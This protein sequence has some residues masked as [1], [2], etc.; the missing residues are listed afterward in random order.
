[1]WRFL[2]KDFISKLLVVDPKRR[3]DAKAALKHPF[4]TKRCPNLTTVPPSASTAATVSTPKSS[5]PI[6]PLH[7]FYADLDADPSIFDARSIESLNSVSDDEDKPSVKSFE[8]TDTVIGPATHAS[9]ERQETAINMDALAKKTKEV[10]SIGETA[11]TTTTANGNQTIRILSYN[12]CIRP[13][14]IKAN[15]NDFKDARLQNFMDNH[16]ANYDIVMLQDVYAR[17]STRQKKLINHAKKLGLGHYLRSP[18]SGLLKGIVD[19]GLV[20]LS[21]YPIV[22]SNRTTF[23]KGL[24]NDR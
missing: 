9:S 24:N 15:S 19:G 20:I 16:L 8:R 1:M 11:S 23:E 6:S 3:M 14:F 17:G 12:L 13:P 7:E 18:A 2:A 4:I 10:V 22:F 5:S 21:R